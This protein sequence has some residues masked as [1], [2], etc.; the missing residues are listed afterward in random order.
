M[1]IQN[2]ARREWSANLNLLLL[3]D[4]CCLGLSVW[5]VLIFKVQKKNF[6]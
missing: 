4:L 5:L 3:G 1:F 6:E 2:K